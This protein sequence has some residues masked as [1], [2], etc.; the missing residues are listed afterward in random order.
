M[1]TISELAQASDQGDGAAARALFAA[2][3]DELHSLAEQQLWR[4]GGQLSLGTT[5]LL[6]EAYLKLAEREGPR[7]P[8]RSRFLAYASKA[9]RGLV[10]DY[11]RARR[12]R[13]RGGQ[14]EITPLGDREPAEAMPEPDE[15]LEQLG[16]A[17][18][19]LSAIDADL[20]QLVDLHFFGGFTLGEI[21]ALQG[22]S[23]RTTER[24]WQKARMLLQRLVND[25]AGGGPSGVG[26][27]GP[28]FPIE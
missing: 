15:R 17:L 20:A 23:L 19:A 12:A 14:F 2:L 26:G 16:Q 22:T 21:A 18:E 3:Y 25:G 4:A 1:A 8:D 13:K 28:G 5:T 6:H 7:F 10:I 24:N 11:A 9:L 27:F